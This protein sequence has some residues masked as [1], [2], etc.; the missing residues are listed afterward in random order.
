MKMLILPIIMAL[1]MQVLAAPA[2]YSLKTYSG[3]TPSVDGSLNEW[4]ETAFIDSIQS[5]ANVFA[6]SSTL[7]WTRNEFQ[8]KLYGTYD[9]LW[10]YFAVKVIADDSVHMPDS[11]GSVSTGDNLK[12][13]PSGQKKSFYIGAN[14]KVSLSTSSPFVLNSTLFARFLKSTYTGNLPHYEFKLSRIVVDPL[15]SEQFILSIGSEDTDN[16]QQTSLCYLAPGVDYTGSKQDWLSNPWD[17]PAYYPTFKL[18]EDTVI[19]DTTGIP[20]VFWSTAAKNNYPLF[21]STKGPAIKGPAILHEGKIASGSV[22]ASTGAMEPNFAIGNGI[23]GTQGRSSFVWIRDL[24]HSTGSVTMA[25]LRGE[26]RDNWAGSAF[27]NSGPIALRIGV[28]DFSGNISSH[29]GEG[30]VPDNAVWTDPLNPLSIIMG[31]NVTI[32]TLM[33]LK[34][35]TIQAPAGRTAGSGSAVLDGNFF[36]IDITDQVNWILSHTGTNKGSYSGQYAIVFLTQPGD[37]TN[38][39]INLYSDE[40]GKDSLLTSAPWTPDGN[41]LHLYMR[42]KNLTLDTATSHCVYA[43]S[44]FSFATATYFSKKNTIQD[45]GA[46]RLALDTARNLPSM[47][48]PLLSCKLAEKDSTGTTRDSVRLVFHT[49]QAAIYLIPADT[50]WV[51]KWTGAL[52]QKVPGVGL[53]STRKTVLVNQPLPGRYTLIADTIGRTDIELN[54]KNIMTNPFSIYSTSSG[55]DIYFTL[56]KTSKCAIALYNT[57]GKLIS[58]LLNDI[59]SNGMHR[60]ISSRNITLPTGVYIARMVT[61][62]ERHSLPVLILK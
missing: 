48:M 33:A 4:P 1:C 34:N 12:V 46:I 17:N 39:K 7:P 22:R 35:K 58:T 51:S 45:T 44:P 2:S 55:F 52:W 20:H 47:Q 3:W 21:V 23:D 30:N 31:Y 13:N 50:L 25:K 19:S 11:A 8:M 27:C 5:D 15:K 6:R 38:G 60:V 43:S 42:S 53:H 14:G 37:G 54:L 10:I 59:Y 26:Y 57:Q 36:E 49:K 24:C 62:D 9:S 16:R 40:T 61:T 56:S 28:V 41:S 18:I 32:P 29:G